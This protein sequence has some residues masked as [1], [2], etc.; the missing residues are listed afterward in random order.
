[1]RVLTSFH[2]GLWPLCAR[3]L[4]GSQQEVFQGNSRSRYVKLVKG[5]ASTEEGRMWTAKSAWVSE[6]LHTTW[7]ENG[8]FYKPS[9]LQVRTFIEGSRA[10]VKLKSNVSNEHSA[11]DGGAA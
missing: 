8:S 2:Y 6:A 9:N 10:P 11:S 5:W 3:N 4:K 1:M 7:A